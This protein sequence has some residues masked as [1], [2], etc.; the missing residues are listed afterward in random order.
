MFKKVVSYKPDADT[1]VVPILTVETNGNIL[2]SNE[3]A[4]ELFGQNKLTGTNLTAVIDAPLEQIFANKGFS[5]KNLFR[6]K[7]TP[8]RYI[9]IKTSQFGQSGFTLVI[10][11]VTD[12]FVMLQKEFV[13]K[14]KIL[15]HV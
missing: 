9:E 4:N 7:T 14:K 1:F 12:D 13:L 6:T 8:E 11:D 2:F 15:Y 10:L 3:Q 5:F